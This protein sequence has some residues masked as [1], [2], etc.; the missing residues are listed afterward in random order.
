MV[1]GTVVTVPPKEAGDLF[2]NADPRLV[3]SDLEEIGHGNFGAVYQVS[4]TS[5]NKSLAKPKWIYA[6]S[7]VETV[8]FLLRIVACHNMLFLAF[9][10]GLCCLFPQARCSISGHVLLF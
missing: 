3:F 8:S 9:E 6:V 7:P 2:I 10:G 5:N 1:R 4:L